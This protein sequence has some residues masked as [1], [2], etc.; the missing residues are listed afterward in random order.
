MK[1][2]LNPALIGMFVLGA[3]ALIV[4]ALLSSRSVHVSSPISTS[5]R[6]DWTSAAR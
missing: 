6:K 3:L 2:K 5:R 1:T 4:V